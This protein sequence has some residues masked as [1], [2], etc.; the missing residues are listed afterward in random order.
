MR[1]NILFQPYPFNPSKKRAVINALIFGL[2]IFLF[3]TLFQPFGLNNYQS[4]TKTLE[5][6]GYGLVTSTLLIF[7]TYLFSIVLP[8]WYTEKKWT[9][10][11]NILFTIWVLFMIGLG[12]LLYSNALRFVHL[13]LNGFVFYQGVTV[14]VGLIPIT[15]STLIV[16]N[17]NLSN[18]IRMAVE[19]NKNYPAQSV[20]S[21]EL[22]QIP[23]RNKSEKIQLSLNDLLALKA[24]EN[25]VEI[26]YSKETQLQKKVIRNTL[27]ELEAHLKS[28]ATIQRCHRS[29]LVNTEQIQSVTGNAQGLI[30]L[31]HPDP[32]LEIPVSRSFVDKLKALA[33]PKP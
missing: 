24:V 25:Y 22:I 15:I 31:L 11:K 8:N 3:L 9:V 5:L 7:N 1:R 14:L 4:E 6:A 33:K 28:Q 29:Y 30:L 21:D 13:G 20:H 27:K 17:K 26:Y 16:Y 2:F 10:G 18:S 32:I 19:L 12:N 23:S